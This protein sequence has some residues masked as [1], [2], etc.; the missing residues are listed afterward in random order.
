M[1]DEEKGLAKIAEGQFIKSPH[2][3][4]INTGMVIRGRTPAQVDYG[5]DNYPNLSRLKPKYTR[6]LRISPRSRNAQVFLDVECGPTLRTHTEFFLNNRQQLLDGQTISAMAYL[7][8]WNGH[9]VKIEGGQGLF[10]FYYEGAALKLEN[11]DLQRAVDNGR[12]QIFGKNEEDWRFMKDSQGNKIGIEMK[13]SRGSWQYYKRDGDLSS[14]LVVP[15]EPNYR[16][17]IDAQM[18][19]LSTQK[20]PQ[21]QYMAWVGETQAAIK[22]GAGINALVKPRLNSIVPGRDVPH[23][24]S[25]LMD[26]CDNRAK[27]QTNWPARL[28]IVSK[29]DHLPEWVGFAMYSNR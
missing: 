2:D 9:A 15:T 14:P 18:T 11:E 17:A 13:I 5:P 4:Q 20:P 24:N 19:R 1:T 26:G 8:N 21:D 22:L 27:N 29:Q 28:E 12:V 3:V 10:R 16:P 25:V 23:T 7:K 6:H